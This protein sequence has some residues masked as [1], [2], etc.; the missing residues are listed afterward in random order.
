MSSHDV[1]NVE[2]EDDAASRSLVAKHVAKHLAIMT[3]RAETSSGL[4]AR[5]ACPAPVVDKSPELPQHQLKRQNAQL[6]EF[7]VSPNLQ[8]YMSYGQARP[9]E[10]ETEVPQPLLL[11]C[12][13][14]H[15]TIT[16]M[17]HSGHTAVYFAGS[18]H[19]G[20]ASACLEV[21]SQC[22]VDWHA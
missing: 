12:F 16:T 22:R 9:V 10:P 5:L 18:P 2:M 1:I 21:P 7:K 14:S 11:W 20:N 6:F 8:Q 4:P 3:G 19:G 13:F 17:M 15:K